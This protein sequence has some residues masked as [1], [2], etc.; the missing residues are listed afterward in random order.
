MA[1]SSDLELSAFYP[2]PTSPA[3]REFHLMCP[4]L[5]LRIYLQTYLSPKCI[6]G[7]NISV[8]STGI[9]ERSIALYQS[10]GS[11]PVF[12]RLFD[13]PIAIMAG[14]MKFFMLTLIRYGGDSLLG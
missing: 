4:V 14:S 8:L 6:C 13:P 7:R 10:I 11:A 3:K 9:K 12:Q 2:E 1:L 5:T